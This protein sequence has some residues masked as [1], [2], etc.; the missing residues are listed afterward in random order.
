MESPFRNGKSY[1]ALEIII[2][3]VVVILQ[4]FL[5]NRKHVN[6]TTASDCIETKHLLCVGSFPIWAYVWLGGILYTAA[7]AAISMQR[8]IVHA[9]VTQSLAI[10][11][12]SAPFV[13]LIIRPCYLAV[14]TYVAIE[15]CINC[16]LPSVKNITDLTRVLL[17]FGTK[18][19]VYIC[20]TAIDKNQDGSRLVIVYLLIDGI[21]MFLRFMF[22]LTQ[23]THADTKSHE[24]GLL[25][26]RLTTVQFVCQ[27]IVAQLIANI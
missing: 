9:A 27:A 5:T 21:V 26:T 2:C 23:P 19:Y 14:I 13:F 18:L 20:Y 22:A 8:F 25:M 16:M 7:L 3:S 1:G 6:N 12:L 24:F 11:L 10:A 17:P 15:F 4:M